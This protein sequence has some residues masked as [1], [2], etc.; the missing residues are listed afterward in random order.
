M[1]PA[2]QPTLEEAL[3]LFQAGELAPA[4]F[5][6]NTLWAQ[7]PGTSEVAALQGQ[8][9]RAARR[10]PEA[11]TWF[12]QSLAAD[13]ADP[14]PLIAIGQLRR[15]MGDPEAARACFEQVVWQTVFQ[16][17]GSPAEA[18]LL[19]DLGLAYIELDADDDAIEALR[20]AL[21]SDPC[22]LEAYRWLALHLGKLGRMSEVSDVLEALMRLQPAALEPQVDRA[23]AFHRSGLCADALDRLEEI[24]AG[25]DHNG[26]ADHAFV[27]VA[28]A[29]GAA[30]LPRM[31]EVASSHWQRLRLRQ[32]GPA[33]PPLQPLE[34]PCQPVRVGILTAEIGN[35]PVSHFLESFLR[36]HNRQRLQVELI[37]TQERGDERSFALRALAAD[38]L[39]LP[40]VSMAE[41]RQ[42]IRERRYQVIVETSGF[43]LAS[44]LDLLTERLAPVQC[45]YVGFHAS[46][47]LETI[48][49]FLAD[50]VLIPPELESQFTER[51]WRLPRP[52]AAYA[53]FKPLPAVECFAECDAPV[54]GSFNQIAKIG[55]DTLAWWAEALRAVPSARMLIKH[56]FAVD[57]A[58]RQRITA[59]LG[60]AGIE[61]NRLRFEGWASSWADHMRSYNKVDVALDATPWSSATTAFEALA[62]GVPLVAIRGATMA[63]R[64]SSAALAGV[65]EPGWIADTPEEFAA[66]A[67][68][69]SANLAALRAGRLER[70]QRALASPLFDAPDLAHHLGKALLAMAA[71]AANTVE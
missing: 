49:W 56:R 46:T 32:S 66:I 36:H 70:Q 3:R 39:L 22:L 11:I 19:A 41:Q 25:S 16:L 27:F 67:A 52:W 14:R 5:M 34:V 60:S 4:E 53:P 68:G 1:I 10:W 23:L 59:A 15:L 54:F 24:L 42:R 62:M 71:S 33:A 64:M 35:H 2:Q 26:R 20:A 55:P 30:L 13:P 21:A 40:D 63:G 6:L 29:A 28:S 51:I 31:R 50:S 9:L 61:A 47:F 45:H 44:G 8:V 7:Q 65:G 18:R 38:S 57:P 58:V 48:D 12:E 69:L 17:A 43:T 37:E